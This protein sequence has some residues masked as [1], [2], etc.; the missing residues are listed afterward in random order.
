MVFKTDCWVCSRCGTR[1]PRK[2]GGNLATPICPSCAPQVVQQLRRYAT[3]DL[4]WPNVIGR[5]LTTTELATLVAR[6]PP[7]P[8]G[9]PPPV[10]LPPLSAADTVIYKGSGTAKGRGR[11]LYKMTNS[12]AQGLVSVYVDPSASG[13]DLEASTL[14]MQFHTSLLTANPP[15]A[16]TLIK[17]PIGGD[18]A[19]AVLKK[20]DLHSVY[21]KAAWNEFPDEVKIGVPVGDPWFGLIHFLSGH[22][23]T[24]NTFLGSGVGREKVFRFDNNDPAAAS[25]RAAVNTNALQA[26]LTVS[27]GAEGLR[28]VLHAGGNKF[29]LIA[30]DNRKL[31]I[32]R[33]GGAIHT[34][35]T[36]YGASESHGAGETTPVWTRA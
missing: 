7:V 17:S 11:V 20:S 3:V 15:S 18:T 10:T 12:L 26:L 25:T 2:Q 31:V 30:N 27:F 35:T 36:M 23:G 6:M 29:I 22:A 5:D 33:Q 9:A 14:R 21:S 24:I 16:A 28:S 19:W 4:D 32:D 1:V 34:L 13:A 8:P